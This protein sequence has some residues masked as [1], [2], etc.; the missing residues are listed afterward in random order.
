MLCESLKPCPH[1]RGNEWGF[2]D[3]RSEQSSGNFPRR[4]RYMGKYMMAQWIGKGRVQFKLVSL[5]GE[6]EGT[7]LRGIMKRGVVPSSFREIWK[8]L[9]AVHGL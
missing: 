4:S 1:Q 5:E 6:V 7:V 3:G 8:S 9:L 2:V